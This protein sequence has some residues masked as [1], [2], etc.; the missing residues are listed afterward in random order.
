[1]TPTAAQASSSRGGGR[2][3]F[4]HISTNWP[5]RESALDRLGEIND[6]VTAKIW[7]QKLQAASG[8]EDAA[9]WRR[10]LATEEA[11]LSRVLESFWEWLKPPNAAELAP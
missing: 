7:L 6:L 11:Q 1:V 8:K 10:L 3:A 9:S 5:C 2:T 4:C